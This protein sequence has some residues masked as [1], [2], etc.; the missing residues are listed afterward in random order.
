MDLLLFQYLRQPYSWPGSESAKP[1]GW[2]RSKTNMAK[3]F[4]GESHFFFFQKIVL[5]PPPSC[6]PK[7]SRSPF[8]PRLLPPIQPRNLKS[9]I[10]NWIL[11]GGTKKQTNKQTP[12][13]PLVPSLGEPP[14]PPKPSPCPQPPPKERESIPEPESKMFSSPRSMPVIMPGHKLR[15]VSPGSH[16]DWEGRTQ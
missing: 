7:P 15:A 9:I 16:R 8:C 14:I 6:F 11:E 1:R 13:E 4:P 3:G 2:G 5:Q 12:M 10:W